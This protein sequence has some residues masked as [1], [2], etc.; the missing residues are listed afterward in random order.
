MKSLLSPEVLDFFARSHEEHAEHM[1]EDC[2]YSLQDCGELADD[3]RVCLQ[4]GLEGNEGVLAAWVS[5]LQQRE[6]SLRMYGQAEKVAVFMQMIELVMLAQKLRNAEHLQ[7]VLRRALRIA[8]P[9]DMQQMAEDMLKKVR[10]LSKGQISR[11]HL[12][13]DVGFMLHQRVRNLQCSEQLRYLLWDSSPQF[14]RDYQM[15][16]VQSVESTDLPQ[17][18]QS[19]NSMFQLWG[20]DDE[21]AV[22]FDDEDAI[23]QDA[24]HMEN[25]QKRLCLHAL[26]TVLI[27][28]GVATFPYKLA[29]LLHSARLEAFN[30]AGLRQ[31]CNSLVSVAS[32]YGVERCL[33]DV[34]NV[35][36]QDVVGWFEETLQSDVELLVSG[37]HALR[38][39]AAGRQVANAQDQDMLED[40]LMAQLAVAIDD[41]GLDGVE[42]H[43][44]SAF[45]VPEPPCLRFD[46]LLGIPGLRH[47]IDN[48]IQGLDEV[49]K[50]YKDNIFLAQQV[51]RLL[52]KRDTKPKL[53][54]RCFAHGQGP[55]LAQDIR[56][57]DGWIHTGRW[58]TVV[59]SVP[60][61]LKVK[62]AMVSCWDEQLFV[63]GF[64]DESEA[65]KR[66]TVQL[67]EDV[68]KA[69]GSP[70]WWGWL[71]M[72]E[73]LSSILRQH[74]AWAESCPCH[75][76]VLRSHSEELSPKLKAQFLRCPM[77]GKRGA[78]LSSG[79]FLELL[80]NLWQM[81]AVQ[82]LR[83]LP[84]D[85]DAGQ[86]RGLIQEFDRARAHLGFYFA[87]KLT[88]LQQM[89]WKVLQIS[90][91]NEVI[92]QMA[93][94]EAL[95]S[96]CVHPLVQR[97]QGPLRASCERWLAGEPL[98]AE[99][100]VRLQQFIASLRL[101][102][103]SERAVEGQHAKVHRHGLGRP[104]HTE[105]FQ[106]Y[107]VRSK[108]MAR[109]LESEELSLE[110]FAWYCQAA[111]NHHQACACVGLLGHPALQN[112]T[113]KHSRRDPLKA[114]II[115]HAD[116]FSLYAAA[117]P[118]V[119]MKPSADHAS[120]EQQPPSI[121]DESSAVAGWPAL[122]CVGV[123]VN[124]EQLCVSPPRLSR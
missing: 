118:D 16:L 54:Q 57:F 9:E 123:L 42:A 79:E 52:R 39:Q 89:P 61:L 25:I 92:A 77:R 106:S 60:E 29:A 41:V 22:S 49:M 44:D 113:Y 64:A 5:R 86:R 93:A 84:A 109:A 124:L 14:G 19:F 121:Q 97:L 76:H 90:H 88:H 66:A 65:R 10:R 4:S 12:T 98:S 7:D 119:R 47:V 120:V 85:L 95:A 45:D 58:G 83:V 48:A 20:S 13:L 94:R 28:F 33:V 103:T 11:A 117:A 72:L 102:P 36:C 46:N 59:F 38:N 34:E 100:M 3:M 68:S 91:S 51:C 27:G 75:Y 40:P 31:W 104:N 56:N 15:C 96:R 69:V 17:I 80:G 99:G 21:N 105:H 108:E 24:L 73:V 122:L 70:V 74:I 87:L 101:V 111:R 63:Q 50:G 116:P 32:D 8:L 55:Q 30:E 81:S 115:Y 114:S 6:D 110:S 53:L 35:G 71:S 2:S 67:A 1:A 43:D 62:H 23:Q 18:L 112:R 26:P 82:V 107:F 37:P 78:E